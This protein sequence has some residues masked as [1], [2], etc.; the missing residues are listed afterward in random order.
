MKPT[1]DIVAE[2]KGQ[3][4]ID[5]INF[6]ARSCVSFSLVWRDQFKFEQSAYEIKQALR[7]FLISNDRTEEWP[8]TTLI[9]HQAIVRRYRVAD[10]SVKL[11]QVVGGLYSWLQPSLPEDLAFYTS[12]ATA[13][14][15]SISHESQAWFLDES[16]RPAEIHAFVPHL[17]ITAHKW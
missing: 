13:W 3:T 10:E 5:L 14:L 11:L 9:G 2:P 1:F 4:Y 12:G 15:A 6:A 17:K 7:P 16:V 8:G